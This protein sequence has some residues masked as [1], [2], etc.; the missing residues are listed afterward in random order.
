MHRIDS[1][2]SVNGLFSAGDPAS[3]Q[4]GTGV[5]PEW[6]N[7]IQ[8]EIAGLIEAM[9][10][11]L[12]KADNTQLAAVILGLFARLNTW[13]ARQTFSDGVT[14]DDI[15]APAGSILR[16]GTTDQ[17]ATELWRNGVQGL[18]LDADAQGDDQLSLHVGS[19]THINGVRE[20]LFSDWAA[21]RSYVD[22]R[23]VKA[24]GHLVV[25]TDGSVTVKPGAFNI[26]GGSIATGRLR[27][28]FAN[29][30]G[31]VDYAICAQFMGGISWIA[32]A[33]HP[34]FTATSFDLMIVSIQTVNEVDIV[35]SAPAG[36]FHIS[37]C[38]FG[39]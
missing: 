27:V 17:Q 32:H 20:P 30:L 29:T 9:G 26:S 8:E 13:T 18:S 25:N 21:P 34:S 12:V 39:P 5:S 36:P 35:A 33:L 10:L 22:A 14:T 3:G 19:A 16:I 24:W 7:A 4:P 1:D 11:T 38:V 28:T 2:A 31:S 6:L 23:G 37:V 15:H